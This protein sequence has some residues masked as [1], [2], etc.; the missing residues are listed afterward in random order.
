MDA[1]DNGGR[2]RPTTPQERLRAAEI[3]LGALERLRRADPLDLA[4]SY[5]AARIAEARAAVEAARIAA[6]AAVAP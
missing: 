5:L 1:S 4:N 6:D 2:Q 3:Y